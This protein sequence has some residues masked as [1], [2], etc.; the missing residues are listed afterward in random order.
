MG[1]HNFS[2][3]VAIISYF[4]TVVESSSSQW[5]RYTVVFRAATLFGILDLAREVLSSY[6]GKNLES[7]C[8]RHICGYIKWV[9]ESILILRFLLILSSGR[10]RIVSEGDPAG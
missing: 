7:S 3:I 2:Q 10:A 8:R 5:E 9:K 1:I 6:K 4:A